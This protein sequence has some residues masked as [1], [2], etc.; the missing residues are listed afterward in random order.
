MVVTIL[1]Q[2]IV[3][4]EFHTHDIILLHVDDPIFSKYLFLDLHKSLLFHLTFKK[5]IILVRI[6]F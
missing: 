6:H 3:D 4:H 1:K 5:I 2:G